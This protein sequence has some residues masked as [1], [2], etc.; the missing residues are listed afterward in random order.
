MQ[1]FKIISF[2]VLLSILTF[3][4]SC[5]K[6]D[7]SPSN[8]FTLNGESFDLS[9]GFIEEYGDNGNDSYDFDV[10]LLSSGINYSESQSFSG[11]GNILYL[12][13]NTSSEDGLV[14]GKYN[15][16]NDRDVFT[17]VD[18]IIATDYDVINETGN[19]FE[20]IGG[21]V[22]LDVDGSE[23]TIDFDLTLSNNTS[24]TGRFK[25]PLLAID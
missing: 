17:L 12:D 25:G 22:D 14:S 7:A 10:T 13:L 15:Y 16:A 8:Q 21:S 9:Q 11:S 1:F 6:D 23:V 4:S 18:A 24:V 5:K 3:S 20:V 19:E 2:I